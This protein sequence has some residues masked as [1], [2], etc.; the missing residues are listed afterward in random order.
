MLSLGGEQA[1]PALHLNRTPHASI[2]HM[3]I[4]IRIAFGGSAN[5]WQDLVAP[6]P[7]IEPSAL[8]EPRAL[9]KPRAMIEP[10][11]L[12][13]PAPLIKPGDTPPPP[14]WVGERL[15]ASN[16]TLASRCEPDEIR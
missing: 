11:F 8:I 7:L 14:S 4:S 1:Y 9:V 10:N 16:M 6:S 2:R 12:I 3:P 13:E 15:A 5:F